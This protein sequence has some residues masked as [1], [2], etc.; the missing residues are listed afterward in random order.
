MFGALAAIAAAAG[1]VTGASDDI[2]RVVAQTAAGATQMAA[3]SDSVTRSISSIAAVSEENSAAAE[4]VSAATEEMSAQAE[5]V[6]A[7]A[8]TLA[9]MATQLNAL[10][11]RFQVA[12]GAAAGGEFEAYRKAHLKWVE[13][14]RAVAGG[15]ARLTPDEVP[16][17]TAC[18][19]GKWLDGP[20]GRAYAGRPE[21]AAIEAPHVRFHKAVRSVA[22]AS[23]AGD[24]RG[25]SAAVREVERLSGDVVQAITNL[26]RGASGPR[27]L[28]RIA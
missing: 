4:E 11:A 6:V 2:A 28:R 15:A 14:A 25:M 5:E 12:A 24:G 1:D 9:D 8:S 17:P 10:V 27:A 23:V 3:A 21:F 18:A 20:G 7:S 13:R 16:A 22:E 19:L 26:E